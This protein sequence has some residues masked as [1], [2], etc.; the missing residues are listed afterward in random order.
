MIIHS[1]AQV[2]AQPYL[3]VTNLTCYSGRGCDVDTQF[4]QDVAEPA[5]KM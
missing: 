4:R 1:A 3:E 2:T 5:R